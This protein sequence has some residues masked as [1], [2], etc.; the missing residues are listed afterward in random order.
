MGIGVCGAQRQ[1]GYVH[2]VSEEHRAPPDKFL[3]IS[4]DRVLTT[5]GMGPGQEFVL[6]KR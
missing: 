5:P 4:R 3:L 1:T 6:S 2:E